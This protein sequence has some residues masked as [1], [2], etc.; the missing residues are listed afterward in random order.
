MCVSA[1]TLDAPRN[2]AGVFANPPRVKAGKTYALAVTGLLDPTFA[3]RNE[4][5][6][7]CSGFHFRRNDGGGFD[8]VRDALVFATLSSVKSRSAGWGDGEGCRATQRPAP[9][10]HVQRRDRPQL[11]LVA[12]RKAE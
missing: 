7:A 2:V 10:V 6:A 4:S 8:E 5:G 9:T 12:R 1:T 11:R 3:L